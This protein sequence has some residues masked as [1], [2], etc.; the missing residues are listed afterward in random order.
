ME[1]PVKVVTDAVVETSKKAVAVYGYTLVVLLAI[2]MVMVGADR[3]LAIMK[4][5]LQLLLWLI[6]KI[7]TV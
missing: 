3:A 7:P 6:T 1:N 4:A 5:G 2:L